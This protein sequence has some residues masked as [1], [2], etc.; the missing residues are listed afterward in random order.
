MPVQILIYEGNTINAVVSVPDVT[1]EIVAKLTRRG[2][3]IVLEGLHVEKLSGEALERQHVH[4]LCREFCLHYRAKKLI[5]RGARR[6]TGRSAGKAK[7]H[8]LQVV[9]T[10]T[11]VRFSEWQ[12]GLKKVALTK[13]IREAGKVSLSQAHQLVNRLLAGEMPELE[14]SSF[15]NARRLAREASTL[16]VRAECVPSHGPKSAAS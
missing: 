13:L 15:Q 5:V 10:M 12:H 7:G 16:G 3:T 6:T 2:G 1:V 9:R 8:H 4:H 14:V 11:V